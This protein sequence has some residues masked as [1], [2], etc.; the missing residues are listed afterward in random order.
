MKSFLCFA[1]ATLIGL[2]A[3][4]QDRIE[5]LTP[6][7]TPQPRKSSVENQQIGTTTPKPEQPQDQAQQD[8]INAEIEAIME[9][10]RQLGGGV[11]EQLGDDFTT[12][13]TPDGLPQSDRTPVQ[14]LDQAFQ[15][16]LAKQLS[17]PPNLST[18]GPEPAVPANSFIARTRQQDPAVANPQ[19]SQQIRQAAR[20]LEE[21][22]AM[23]EEANE[24]QH[25]DSVRSSA[26]ELW[27]AA[28]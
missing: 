22:A 18:F 2:L 15:Q 20:M 24:Y 21:A 17:Q 7:P 19:R 5:P 26:A 1:V 12:S 13:M 6:P 27:R 16:Q 9:I 8:R 28:R 23:L 11:I 3:L 25:A 14:K 10:R 4:P